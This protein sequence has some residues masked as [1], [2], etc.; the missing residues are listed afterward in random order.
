MKK[1]TKLAKFHIWEESGD[2]GGFQGDLGIFANSPQLFEAETRVWSKM[3]QIPTVSVSK[4]PSTQVRRR[5]ELLEPS[6]QKPGTPEKPTQNRKFPLFSLY[7]YKGIQCIS[8]VTG[9]WYF[10]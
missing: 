2:V 9:P 4:H 1:N 3:K 6:G 7:N 10:A 5:L 8:M